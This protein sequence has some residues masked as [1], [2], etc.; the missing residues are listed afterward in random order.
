M[1]MYVC[2]SYLRLQNSQ[3]THHSESEN[4][5]LFHSTWLL[6]LSSL[7]SLLSHTCTNKVNIAKNLT[8]SIHTCVLTF[9]PIK[10]CHLTKSHVITNSNSNFT[11]ISI[12]DC[13]FFPSGQSLR[14]FET[15]TTRYINIKQMNLEQYTC[16]TVSTEAFTSKQRTK[17]SLAQVK[18][19]TSVWTFYLWQKQSVYGKN[20]INIISSWQNKLWTCLLLH[21]PHKITMLLHVSTTISLEHSPVAPSHSASL[22]IPLTFQHQCII[23]NLN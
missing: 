18:Y 4:S 12:K 17:F 15:N 8:H 22:V 20:V 21:F 10:S 19:N 1:W 6:F 3:L 7:L 2:C 14:L 23:I 16:N 9:L 11:N 13:Q 5:K